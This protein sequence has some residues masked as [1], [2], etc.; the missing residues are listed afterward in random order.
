M[1]L[2]KFAE[3]MRGNVE[4]HLADIK[5]RKTQVRKNKG[6]K[7]TGLV[8]EAKNTNISPTVYMVELY[9]TYQI[10]KAMEE[11]QDAV[12][13]KDNRSVP[14]RTLNFDVYKEYDKE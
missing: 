10:G 1:T 8:F 5:V 13:D 11:V 14:K 6:V 12:G 7:L 4:K 3:K 9:D 2:E